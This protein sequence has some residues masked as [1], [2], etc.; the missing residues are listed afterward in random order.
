M[1]SKKISLWAQ[2]KP[3][4]KVVY[5]VRF[6]AKKRGAACY[7][8]GFNGKEKD[9][10]GEWG[11]QTHYDYGFR[12]YN[13]AIGKFLSVDP[14]MNKFASLTSYQFASNMP[15]VAM[16]LEGL[17]L[18]T[19]H[20]A[21]ATDKLWNAM[22]S[23]ATKDE[24][25]LMVAEISAGGYKNA[26][27]ASWAKKKYESDGKRIVTVS[28]APEGQDL[29]ILGFSNAN[30]D[31]VVK[32][33]IYSIASSGDELVN[34]AKPENVSSPDDLNESIRA[35]ISNL[36]GRTS[37]EVEGGFTWAH[38]AASAKIFGREAGFN[39]QGGGY[40]L[41]GKYNSQTGGESFIYDPKTFNIVAEGGIGYL[42]ANYQTTYKPY[43]NTFS[44]E[45]YGLGIGP[46]KKGVGNNSLSI[47]V[48]KESIF[49]GPEI[50]AAFGVGVRLK[51]GVRVDNSTQE[52]K[53]E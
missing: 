7:R 42:S 47:G 37:F 35:K 52:S 29:V 44:S 15:I 10:E 26:K 25:L 21:W 48:E 13:P 39:F 14:L 32:E 3:T 27:S 24:L 36:W 34:S 1:G 9:T 5:G 8:F 53:V 31:Y 33:T 50:N 51:L 17:E 12:I 2:E 30:K 11:T 45:S 38:A 20:S 19:V 49:I 41:G 16:D 6:F 28:P 43:E 18:Y 46:L 23:G 22:V 40:M 4:L